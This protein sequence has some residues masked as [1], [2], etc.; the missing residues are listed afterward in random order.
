MKTYVAEVDSNFDA[1]FAQLPAEVDKAFDQLKTESPKFR[2]SYRRLVSFQAWRAEIFSS[3]DHKDAAAFFTEAHNDV[4][5]SHALARQAAWRVAL[6]SLRSAIE[7]T[8]FCLY[9]LDHS[10]ELIHWSKGKHKLGFAEVCDYLARHPHFQPYSASITGLPQIA[11]EYSTLS[12]AVHGS[13]APFRVTKEGNVL[14]LHVPSKVELNKWST[15]E[16]AVAGA[17]NL[18]LL[19]FFKLQLQGAAH[20]RLRKAISLAVPAGKHS[21]VKSS[22]GVTLR[23]SPE[24]E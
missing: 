22:F 20:V 2:E 8:L 15:R 10:V 21:S 13:A 4:L 3:L 17:L 1:Y 11:R 18:V 16:N 12:K 19:T 24:N 6:M 5:M 7:N 14:G 9:Y 23:A